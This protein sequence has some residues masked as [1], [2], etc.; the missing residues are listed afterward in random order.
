MAGC[1]SDAPVGNSPTDTDWPMAGFDPANTGYNPVGRPP[2]TEVAESWRTITEQPTARPVVVE[3]LVYLPDI[4]AV[5]SFA[6]GNGEARWS[7]AG[8]DDARFWASPTVAAWT[9]YQADSRGR[10]FALDARTGE[11]RWR[12]DLETSVFGSP[13]VGTDAVYVGTSGERVHR[14]DARS[15]QVDWTRDV[16][17]PVRDACAL[18]ES[19]LV[20]VTRAGRVYAMRPDGRFEWSRQLAAP[21]DGPATV[22]G[23]TVFVTTA[24]DRILAFEHGTGRTRWA[25]DVGDRIGRG[26]AV[27]GTSVYAS[28]DTHLHAIDAGTGTRQ[29]RSEVRGDGE[30]PPVVVGESV[31]VSTAEAI[32]AMAADGG[33]GLGTV[34]IGDVQWSVDLEASP[35]TGLTVGDRAMYAPVR[36]AE[37]EYALLAIGTEG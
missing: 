33:T 29:W 16:V 9:V 18:T 17:G 2:G 13:I 26:V 25:A 19:A 30:W 1:V 12:V 21:V 36:V 6:V 3:N 20:V 10:V 24:D 4:K 28:G 35:V 27:A 5:R 8:P 22:S 32:Y 31:F 14:I 34:R 7:F 37:G 11:E 23:D 15:G